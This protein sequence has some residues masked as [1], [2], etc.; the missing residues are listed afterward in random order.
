M[1]VHLLFPGMV[2][3]PYVP[4]S[5]WFPAIVTGPS[6]VNVGILFAPVRHTSSKGT[7]APKIFR[8]LM[9]GLL[10]FNVT[11]PIPKLW[12]TVCELLAG[13]NFSWASADCQPMAIVMVIRAVINN[14]FLILFIVSY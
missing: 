13:G 12:V 1:M 9:F 8:P 2:S 6:K 7:S 14:C 11:V 10:Y 5:S 4:A 3:R